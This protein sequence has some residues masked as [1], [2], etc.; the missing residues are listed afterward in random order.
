MKNLVRVILLLLTLAM[1]LHS[2]A[3]KYIKEVAIG[4]RSGSNDAINDLKNKG[5]EVL[6]NDLNRNAGG[7]FIYLGYKTTDDPKEAIT[8][9]VIFQDGP[10][11]WDGNNPEKKTTYNNKTYYPVPVAGNNDNG[12][13]TRRAGGKN[14]FLWY[15]R[16]QYENGVVKNSMY[17]TSNRDAAGN[18]RLTGGGA[19]DFNWGAGG[20][21]I[22]LNISKEIPKFSKL[23]VM[24]EMFQISNLGGG[25]YK[26]DIPLA[27][28]IEDKGKKDTYILGTN[29]SSTSINIKAKVGNV[30]NDV[31][32]LQGVK[33]PKDFTDN[34]T[35]SGTLQ[36]GFEFYDPNTLRKIDK[37][38]DLVV[39]SSNKVDRVWVT[40]F[41]KGSVE[42]EQ[43][44]MK[45]TGTMNDATTQSADIDV[46]KLVNG[47][48][49]PDG[50][51]NITVVQPVL[52][53]HIEGVDGKFLQPQGSQLVQVV[54]NNAIYRSVVW[55][56]QEKT[57]MP[58][59]E[60]AAEGVRNFSLN[61]ESKD[62]TQRFVLLM[63]GA[64][65]SETPAASPVVAKPCAAYAAP[66]EVKAFHEI[67]DFSVTM[68][69][70]I[71]KNGA[72]KQ[73]N[74]LTWTLHNY[75]ESDVV[76]SDQI[77]VQRAHKPNFADAQTIANM[78]LYEGEQDK[79]DETKMNFTYVD[80]D[81]EGWR[82]S[83]NDSTV[84]K[85]FYRVMRALPYSLWKDNCDKKY[86]TK[87]SITL[88]NFLAGVNNITFNKT[89]N[90]NA[91]KTVK[92]R[93]E[94]GHR[95]TALD[96]QT[97]SPHGETPVKLWN[98]VSMSYLGKIEGNNFKNMVAN[99]DDA[100]PFILRKDLGVAHFRLSDD[101]DHYL[102]LDRNSSN[103]IKGKVNDSGCKFF[104]IVTGSNKRIIEI[105]DDISVSGKGNMLALTSDK[106][107]VENKRHAVQGEQCYWE[108]HYD[109]EQTVKVA[110]D[111]LMWDPN[112]SIKI[113][114]F[115]PEEEH[116]QGKDYA[117]KTIII[118]GADVKWDA[119]KKQWYAEI[120]DVQ[121]APYTH[122]YYKAIVDASKSY[123]REG[124]NEGYV[125][126]KEEADAC[127]SETLAPFSKFE[128]TQG[129]IKGKIAVEW[130]V[131]DG[132]VDAFELTRK[133]Y[134]SNDKP[135]ALTLKSHKSTS[136]VD[137]NAESGVVYE[138]TVTAK[139]SVRGNTYTTSKTTYGWNPYFATISGTVQMPN[140]A[141][142]PG[143]VTI[144]V[145]PKDNKG[146]KV[147]EVRIGG[148]VIM[149]GY[150][151]VYE[152]KINT[153]NG[154]FSFD[155]IPYISGG[156]DY[157]VTVSAYNSDVEYAGQK[158]NT[159]GV[160]LNDA[161]YK[162]EMNF[163]IT[164]TKRFS[165][166]VLYENS[167]IPVSECM[168]LMNGYPVL[169]AS[170][171]TL[172]T[173]NKG[174]FS[175]FMPHV[176]MT[177]QACKP[178]H[179]L[180]NEGYIEGINID[181]TKTGEHTFL[182]SHD[183]DGLTLY[184]KT[185]VRLVGRMIGGN[186]Q[187]NLPVGLGVTK[188]NL[189][190]NM[191]MI[192]E[193]EGD[194]AASIL[195]LKDQ[196]EVTSLKHTYT[197]KVTSDKQG[198]TEVNKTAV[199][200]EKKR[201]VVVPDVKTGEFC[202]DLAPT[203]Y[204]ITELSATGYTTLFNDGEGF[205]VLNLSNDTTVQQS[206]YINKEN[207]EKLTTAYNSRYQKVH[208][209]PVKVTYTQS[210]Y[211]ME[212]KILGAEKISEYNLK[213]ERV[214]ATVAKYDKASDKVTYMFG[215]PVFEEGQEYQLNISAHEDYYYNG[216]TNTIPDIVHLDSGM[217]K[218]RNGLESSVSEQEY[219]L[220]SQGMAVIDI[221]AGNTT[222]NLEEEDALRSITIQVLNNGYY[223]EAKP[224]QAYVTGSREKGRDVITLDSDVSVL[225]VVRDPYG[226]GSYAY[227]EA[228]TKYHWERE[229]NVNFSSSLDITT[230][231][232][233]SASTNVGVW[234][235]FGGGAYAGTSAGSSSTVS[236]S[237]PIPLYDYGYK[238]MAA[239]DMT[240]TNRVTTSNDPFQ[241]GA[242]ADVYIGAVNTVDV[243]RR[244]VFCVIDNE[245]Y[246]MVKPAIDAKAIRIVSEGKDADDKP[247][248]LAIAEKMN[249]TLGQPR[250]FVYT[251]RY[252]VSTLIPNL[253]QQ[254]KSM[255]LTGTKAE[256]Q[257]IADA[258]R[259][260]QYRLKDGK[261]I[262]DE[263][264]YEKISPAGVQHP[265]IS[266][267]NPDNC[268]NMINQWIEVIA[269][270]ESKKV[271]AIQS[272]NK[273][274]RYSLSSNQTFEH[275]EAAEWY[276]K[277]LSI[278]KLANF[279][280]DAKELS[281][282][283]GIGVKIPVSKNT[284]STDKTTQS[285]NGV[286]GVA[287]ETPGVKFRFN[288][289]PNISAGVSNNFSKLTTYSGGSGYVLATND[290]GYLDIDV[291]S[292]A[293]TTVENGFNDK[294]WDFV[295]ALNDKSTVEMHDFIY[296]LRGGAAR[297]PWLE[298][299]S[300]LYY[301]MH[302]P[303]STRTLRIDNPRIYIDQPMVSNLPATEKAF[304]SVR[305]INETELPTGAD[306]SMY[307]PSEFVLTLDDKS[308]AD[309]AIITMDGMPIKAGVPFI[310]AP[311]ES[312]T[313][314]IQ[315][316]RSGKAY[317]YD[318]IK[319]I[320]RDAVNSLSDCAAFS[321]HYMPTSTPVKLVRPVDKWVM[322]TLSPVDEH[323]KY[324]I[325]VEVTGFN[326]NHDNFDHI[327]L[328]YKKNTDGD[329]KW[330]N[331]CSYY[332]NKEL[333]D[334][335]SGEKA[336]INGNITH[337]F[338]GEADP[339][340]MSY[341]LRAVSFCRF[342]SGF[343]TST[344]NVMT[345][346][347]DTRN[348]VVFGVPKPGN[349]VLTFQD[350][351]SIPFN[352][353]I[354]YN[355]LDETANFS[356]QGFVNGGAASYESS[357]RFPPMTL[358]EENEVEETVPTTL[359][360]RNLNG[361]DFTW[362][363]M[364][365]F[366]EGNDFGIFVSISDQEE[367]RNI[368]DGYFIFR[369]AGGKL[370]AE[371]NG[372]AFVSRS[373]QESE[374]VRLYNSLMQKMTHVAVTFKQTN[375][376]IKGAEQLHFYVDG[377]EIPVDSVL[378]Y[379][380]A[381]PSSTNKKVTCDANG[382]IRVGQ[383][384]TGNM[385]DV[386]MWDKALSISEL[387]G[388]SGK[389]LTGA[390]P[391]L[392]AYW[393]MNELQ[394]K[395]LYDKANGADMHF[396]RQT[397]QL[398]TGLHSLKIEGQAFNMQ[399]TEKFLRYDNNDFTLGYWFKVDKDKTVA[400][401]VAIF[402]SGSN[403]DKEKMTMYIDADNFVIK[404]GQ[405]AFNIMPR[406]NVMDGQWHNTMI[407]ANKSLNSVAFYC[408]GK[409]METVSG[410]E[411]GGMQQ[412]IQLGSPDFYGNIDNLTFWHLAFP[413]NSLDKVFQFS[414]KGD[415]MGLVYYLPFEK[416]TLNSQG[417][418]EIVFSTYN[419]VITKT[420]EGT[421]GKKNHAFESKVLNDKELLKRMD[422]AISYA[423]VKP[424]DGVVNLPFTWTASNNELQINIMETDAKINH[425][426]ISV[427]VRD[428][429]DLAGNPLINPQ[430]MM[431]FVDRNVLQWEKEG[432][433]KNIKYGEPETVGVSFSNKSGR[434][435]NYR[436]EENCSWLTP[437]KFNGSL[438]ALGSDYIE[439]E[440]N[441]GL[442]P[443]EYTATVYLV[444]ED[445]LTSP[446]TFNVVVTGEE[447]DW[448]VVKSKD[449]SYSM[450]IIG[451]VKLMN[452]GEAEYLDMDERDIVGVF[453]NG[454]CI[455][456]SNITVDKKKNSSTVNLT[457]Y[458]NQNMLPK[459]SVLKYLTFQ[460]WRASTNEVSVLKPNTTNNSI[461]FQNNGMVGCP[462]DNPVIFTL[463]NEHK[464]IIALEE[465]WNWISLNLIP[466]NTIGVNGLF[467]SNNAFTEGDWISVNNASSQLVR[468]ESGALL[469]SSS[470]DAVKNLDKHVY[471]IYAQNPTR[472]TVFGYTYN[473][474]NRFVK[475]LPATTANATYK[476]NE[477]AYLLTVD[478]PI[479]IAMSDFYKDKA[480]VGTIIKSLTQ[481]AVMSD[482]GW[483]GSLQYMHPGQ[484]YFVKYL[485][486]KEMTIYYTNNDHQEGKAKQT[487]LSYEEE[488]N[489][490]TLSMGSQHASSMPVIAQM[491]EEEDL[492]Q[493][494]VI[495]AYTKGEVA[496]TAEPTV[497]EDG[498][499][500]F[501]LS[502]NADNGD[503]V[504]FAHIRDGEVLAKSSNGVTF[505]G[506]EV[507]GTLN[508][509]YT[510]NF[511]Q[512]YSDDDD[513][514]DIS[515]N[516]YGKAENIKNR[517]GIFI[518]NNTKIAK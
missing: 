39:T 417:S 267:I 190:D 447:P 1:P 406:S 390:E 310:L 165:G 400:D 465:G 22:F 63:Q 179:T 452:Q 11:G 303:L 27:A 416:D 123:Y 324:Y 395:V 109:M 317:N 336:L 169:D 103:V 10:G 207:G 209:N 241:A 138:Y 72:F 380:F 503:V 367:T 501:F 460:I 248:Y 268:L 216:N 84:H 322:N 204:K 93:V 497:M 49:A 121:G 360:K 75:R 487:E 272:Y 294:Q 289:T 262:M 74:T 345:G 115:S 478:K 189:G 201:I 122:F 340:E 331:M 203:K 515:G 258:T 48:K 326:V 31:V 247:F 295:N 193:L 220:D 456:K 212:Q 47:V 489:D 23:P 350:V 282:T 68:T 454:V 113:E 296:V 85:V 401:S 102:K 107:H 110:Q 292:V 378:K 463:S 52:N 118:N 299:D 172:R 266:P 499:K 35:V 157:E 404:S 482:D 89:E 221:K 5:F 142:V 87:D 440:I 333:Y 164:D 363:G 26:I 116:Y 319:L 166:R 232:G 159:F 329:S 442:A 457:V 82:D 341:D 369:Y 337:R 147:N 73:K 427:T 200:V 260:V 510:I 277:V 315:V 99:W 330:V 217:V 97:L 128:A 8:D 7:N 20:D 231:M 33:K 364:V 402:Q 178:G 506:E 414:P 453:Y 29:G 353:P 423:P 398:A 94:L 21:Y 257:A 419:E 101:K 498:R 311:G 36:S 518:I 385:A 224:L 135:Q 293:A 374:Y 61:I 507:T 156:I 320:F 318:G 500:L 466:K 502:L 358:P 297:Q 134:N 195:Y 342:G 242:M 410:T 244:D 53:M 153:D 145:K 38:S 451:Q 34:W 441:D 180:D 251:Q 285:D 338:Y 80:E 261:T 386:R 133:K 177:L 218:V 58:I 436:I 376:E 517:H 139:C 387:N 57:F 483:V 429:E 152:D 175:F 55:N 3:G 271:A 396:T 222:F 162:P 281:G 211:G 249:P 28:I 43:F 335:A 328:Q 445:N 150:D 389:V 459:N 160:R 348:P 480:P 191:K 407:V 125:T 91:D 494:D 323:G 182:P 255:I 14:I 64:Y 505:N 446:F 397:W 301:E 98:T 230:E 192:L 186:V 275:T 274:N 291:Y 458:G 226:S 154:T 347:K 495:V 70:E 307:N 354:A 351:I 163:V 509:P 321:V 66:F 250:Q 92:I 264:C 240:L 513:A 229:F 198:E 508:V 471:K 371:M 339:V 239:Y 428:V 287:L 450:N 202:L 448:N 394:G 477:L 278:H 170:G 161:N 435:V 124:V 171:D 137:E 167:T 279:N 422:D 25:L 377:V 269:T 393:P 6:G 16:D 408:D 104:F 210:K 284:G 119:K 412:A 199:T 438:S 491:N 208:H 384:F 132:L 149:P 375:D 146:V 76:D 302:T 346:T 356:V 176:D 305:M 2:W 56:P 227:R 432:I 243:A 45:A 105:Y 83:H 420:A 286:I 288:L 173:D 256:V 237:I 117:M 148:K 399:D 488:T 140:G 233:V 235:G 334:K 42:Y 96:F 19:C 304:F 81:E 496:A 78:S 290:D 194:N 254:Y 366:D 476:W 196:P 405:N 443:G 143:P 372:I 69:K 433:S 77:L 223:Y 362:E 246:K 355:Y 468:N 308:T 32:T 504:R 106:L 434:N 469:W 131:E 18:V 479:H 252:I 411:F 392:M 236:V 15:T 126:S 9:M 205:E 151:K 67:H 357:L 141:R 492:Q 344:S 312:I 12:D 59:E 183:Y 65:S 228:G 425:Q 352:E 449:Y 112:A 259:T 50:I 493:G 62:V 370:R 514:F 114:R 37:L 283:L 197:Q 391:S 88:R 437:S 95:D 130:A 516:S 388:Y 86:M 409:L 512:M 418:H 381:N 383:L 24:D 188:N 90:F 349:G 71:D 306:V 108:L 111:E 213:G 54:S 225:D 467:E 325:P 439:F 298:P 365:K 144:S 474:D 421:V 359:V 332:F 426:Y 41:C 51:N 413:S 309:G 60:M 120:E 79:A 464:Q 280:L 46:I 316:E 245:T 187:G 327:E 44:E 263:A 184:D 424:T 361:T 455:G 265:N 472:I 444:D 475:I 127:Y 40:L 238:R 181:K 379:M 174:N 314:T 13:L 214:T 481:F 490:L 234:A 4:T 100:Q 276:D 158:G 129:T 484:G 253:V 219:Q 168:F 382:R 313:K 470:V 461:A 30:S 431:V 486:T 215:Y 300:T 473:D 17:V 430:M 185:K 373:L 206:I 270:N 343:V 485:G 155:N 136:Y 511:S 462:P 368:N 403:L 273:C 415:E